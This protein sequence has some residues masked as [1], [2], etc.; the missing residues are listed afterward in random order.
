MR[1][2]NSQIIISFAGGIGDALL[3]V[4]WVNSLSLK[5][6][7]YIVG[8]FTQT[9]AKDVVNSLSVINETL[10]ED[11][12]SPIDKRVMFSDAYYSG[13]LISKKIVIASLLSG[14]KLNALY[15][16]IYGRPIKLR[17]FPHIKWL[18]M[19]KSTPVLLQP[20]RFDND[21]SNYKKYY[22]RKLP[23]K[24]T[25]THG[26]QKTES[27]GFTVAIQIFSVVSYKDLPFSYWKVVI[28]ELLKRFRR[29]KILVIGTA[30]EEAITN[31]EIWKSPRLINYMGTFTILETAKIIRESDYFIGLD[32]GLMHIA[33]CYGVPSVTVWGPT[34]HL[35]YGY[36]EIDPL[37][38]RIVT[39]NLPCSPCESP[40]RHPLVRRYPDPIACKS[41]ECMRWTTPDL[42]VKK[43]IDLFDQEIV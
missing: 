42:I 21:A 18:E 24:T 15:S 20:F 37:R 5:K 35:A 16:E 6:G 23:G 11:E 1:K 3:M 7:N 9:A 28:T 13:F 43:C 19:D 32:S 25:Y 2:K 10:M 27:N 38:H 4:P 36:S 40:L 22:L 29:L 34:D 12:L 30:C 8:I 39:L 41:R 17:I 33:Y 31:D 14:K 26:L